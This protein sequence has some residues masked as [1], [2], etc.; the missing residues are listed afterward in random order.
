[1]EDLPHHRWIATS[2]QATKVPLRVAGN[3]QTTYLNLT[4]FARVSS[5]PSA[6]ALALRHLGIV[7]LPDVIAKPLLKTGEM[8]HLLEG[9]TGPHWP[10]FSVHAYGGEKPVH[11]NRFNQLVCRYFASL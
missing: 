3:A 9:T 4:P 6:V 11:I 1:M 8:V 2:W 10:I 7:L 5:L